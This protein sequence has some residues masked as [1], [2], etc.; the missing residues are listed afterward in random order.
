V[1]R[2]QM[3]M[4]GM[5][6]PVIKRL[7][8]VNVALWIGGVLILQNMF[9]QE[10]FLFRWFGLVPY[11]V[12]FEFHIWQP[13]TY[14]FL[15]ASNVFHVVFNMLM[16][17]MLGSELESRWGGRFFLLYYMVSGVGAALLYMIAVFV[18]YLI[19]NQFLPLQI[20]V[21]GASGAVFGL[22]VAYGILFGERTIYFMMMFP[23][24]AK[25]FVMILAGIEIV[26]L[27]STGLHGDVA[28]LAHLGGLVSGYLFL[29]F[30]SQWK[31]GQKPSKPRKRGRKLKLVVDNERNE[32]SD[33]PR[34]WN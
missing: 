15:H 2:V 8:I 13:F 7:I 28:N 26:S 18:Y 4:G 10:N 3:Q 22:F 34:Y 25:H 33:G 19:S 31:R 16:L 12:I 6:T 29:L 14:M 17:W 32:G 11:K 1:N 24:K 27:L 20:P 9:L 21:V 5:L 30:W 23:M